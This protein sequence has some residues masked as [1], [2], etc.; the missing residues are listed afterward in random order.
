VW[1]VGPV[2]PV[3]PVRL[4]G[5]VGLVRLV[6][7]AHGVTCDAVPLSH[8]QTGDAGKRGKRTAGQRTVAQIDGSRAN[9][10]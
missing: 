4:V 7:R 6:R 10:P 3:R 1:P 2:G 5:L 8:K 9:G